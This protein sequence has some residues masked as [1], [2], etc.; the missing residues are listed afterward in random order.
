MCHVDHAQRRCICTTSVTHPHTAIS[1]IL[2][3]EA[4]HIKV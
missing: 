3:N 2:C 1:I 4:S